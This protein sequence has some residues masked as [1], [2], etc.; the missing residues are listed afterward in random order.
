MKDDL[1]L[2]SKNFELILQE[3]KDLWNSISEIEKQSIEK[4]LQD[5]ETGKL[6]PHLKAKQLYEKWL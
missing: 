6:N 1:N 4:G 3:S 2:Q 5:A